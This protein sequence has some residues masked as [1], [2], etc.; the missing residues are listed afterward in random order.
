MP[1]LTGNDGLLAG[2]LLAAVR[3]GLN[4]RDVVSWNEIRL[5]EQKNGFA[6]GK[7]TL[8]LVVLSRLPALTVPSLATD[9]G[10][11][12]GDLLAAVGAGLDIADVVGWNVRREEERWSERG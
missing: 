6:F 4:V 10:L 5:T 8:D 11:L 12:A 3:A 9:D 2:N 7:R 1:G